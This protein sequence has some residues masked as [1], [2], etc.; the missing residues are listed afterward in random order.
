MFIF[1]ALNLIFKCTMKGLFGVALDC[2]K[3]MSLRFSPAFAVYNDEVLELNWRLIKWF[4]I[5]TPVVDRLRNLHK[6][7][8][9]DPLTD[10]WYLLCIGRF[11]KME[12]RKRALV[13]RMLQYVL[14]HDVLQI[15]FPDILIKRTL[16][17]K[18]YLVWSFPVTIKS[19]SNNTNKALYNWE[20]SR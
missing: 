10:M 1:I 9:M 13:S 19:M 8:L 18:P 12:D 3:K 6:W 15:P 14:V 16:E 11:V 5:L 20:I 4:W 17:G 7:V 2:M